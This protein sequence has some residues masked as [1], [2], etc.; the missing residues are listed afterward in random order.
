M[1]YGKE[2]I[3]YKVD[4]DPSSGWL[5]NAANSVFWCRIR[6]VMASQCTTMYQKV[7]ST[8]WSATAIITDFDNWQAQFPEELWR[9]DI[10]RK[11]LRTYQG[12]GLNGGAAASPTP[13]F[14]KSM[15]QGRKKYQRRQWLRDQE[16]YFGTKYLTS[17][18]KSDQ[19]MFRCNTPSAAVVAPNYTL[20]IVPYSDMYLSVMF[21]NSAPSQIRAKAGTEYEISC[22]YSTMDDTAV[23]IYCASKIQ[24]LN[25][26]SAAYIHDN[27]FSKATKLKKLVIGSDIE[28]YDNQFLTSLNMGDNV[29]LQELDVR[30]CGSLAGDLNLSRCNNL[31]KLYAE[32]TIL[33]SIT[34]AT[35]GKLQLAHLPGTIKSLALRYLNYLTDLQ[36]E[37]LDNLDT[38][39][40]EHSSVDT[41]SIATDAADTLTSIKLLGIDWTLQNTDLLDALLNVYS[42]SLAGKVYVP[43]IQQSKLA[44]YKEAWGDDLKISY[45]T[46]QKQYLVTFKNDDGTI[47]YEEYVDAGKTIKDPIASG[48]LETPTKESTISTNFA[49]KSWDGSWTEEGYSVNI[50]EATTYTAQYTESVRQYTVRWYGDLSSSGTT[51]LLQETTVNY[52]AAATY[53]GEIPTYT[54][55]EAGNDFYLFESWDNFTGCVKGDIDVHARWQHSSYSFVKDEDGKIVDT[56]SLTA[57]DIYAITKKGTA[58]SLLSHKDRIKIP[59]GYLPVYDNVDYAD[60]ATD[61]EMTGENYLD[62]GVK[63]PSMDKGW[64]FVVN[65]RLFKTA[66]FDYSEF[67]SYQDNATWVSCFS[68]DGYMG[69]KIFQKRKGSNL[70]ENIQW[71]TNTF[72]SSHDISSAQGT[73]KIVFVIRHIAG[74]RDVEVY[75]GVFL[76]NARIYSK[77]STLTKSIDTIATKS[78]VFGAY[79][80]DQGEATDY[81]TGM[82]YNCR[83]YYEDLG[84]KECSK[85]I[86]Y[87]M[88]THTYEVANFGAQKTSDNSEATNIDFIAAAPLARFIGMFLSGDD[89]TGN[90]DKTFVHE[91]LHAVQYEGYTEAWKSLIKKCKINYNQYV[92]GTNGELG[93]CDAYVWIPSYSEVAKL[94]TEP[95]V[96]SGQHIPFFIDNT[97]RLKTLESIVKDNPAV[98]ASSTDPVLNEEN[99]V[100]A[101]D[102][103][104]NSGTYY[105]RTVWETWQNAVNYRLR[106]KS[107]SASNK[108]PIITTIGGINKDYSAALG[109][110]LEGVLPCFSV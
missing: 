12:G 25:D 89:D 95:W 4:G 8:C 63:L 50:D 66:L 54:D 29:L 64:T 19:I 6:D 55:A 81:G 99:V 84:L 80:N 85:I 72:L 70:C 13:R 83:L 100:E 7:N 59:M 35:N 15:L 68:D 11:Y 16:D 73:P 42:S 82:I 51:I 87:P 10:E 104:D 91:W 69:F 67:T 53:K 9:L 78:I 2:D 74:S 96:Y 21:G 41:L 110:N 46:L 18:V 48:K 28:G 58:K 32:G 86:S 98:Y 101:G 26:L 76:K 79:I 60:L 106:D 102:I 31:E 44:A 45:T 23:L 52:G 40:I 88:D 14:L 27:D 94:S 93:T 56:E 38:L 5:F 24:S 49:Y 57:A 37:S 1:S 3:D 109:T 107:L 22:P 39:V 47:L 75:E 33:A 34:F 62:T 97:S 17:N 30:N 20:R 43:I 103:W 61:F 71:G 65:M 90:Y 92:D 108:F 105:I 36:T 77:T